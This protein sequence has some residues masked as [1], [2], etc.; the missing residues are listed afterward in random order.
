MQ[1]TPSTSVQRIAVKLPAQRHGLDDG[2]NAAT[3]AADAKRTC[4]EGHPDGIAPVSFYG[5]LGGRRLSDDMRD[6]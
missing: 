5:E 1:G 6:G 4:R 2:G 3:R